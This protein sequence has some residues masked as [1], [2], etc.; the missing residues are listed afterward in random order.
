MLRYSGAMDPAEIEYESWLI[1]LAWTRDERCPNGDFHDY[2]SFY[3]EY[4]G[5]QCVYR[6][7]GCDHH[8]AIPF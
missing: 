1:E 3:A 6:C 2:Q 5:V 8:T 4:R 7:Q